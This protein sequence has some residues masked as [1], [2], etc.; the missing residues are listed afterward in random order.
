MT[1]V[2]IRTKKVFKKVFETDNFEGLNKNVSPEWDSLKH[3]EL[4]LELEDEF[5]IEFT[6]IASSE[7]CDFDS[8]VKTILENL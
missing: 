7:I 1:T 8:C 6:N 3:I 5:A 4:V 2:E